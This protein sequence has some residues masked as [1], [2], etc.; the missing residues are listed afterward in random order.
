MQQK[1]RKKMQLPS[2]F[3]NVYEKIH[4]EIPHHPRFSKIQAQIKK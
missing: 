1:F 2:I 3:D 4:E